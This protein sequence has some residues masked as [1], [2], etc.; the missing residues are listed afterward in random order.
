MGC[1][2]DSPPAEDTVASTWSLALSF[3]GQGVG[4]LFLI[5]KAE[6]DSQLKRG[7]HVLRAIT[8]PWQRGQPGAFENVIINSDPVSSHLIA[9]SG[10][11]LRLRSSLILLR[12]VRGAVNGPG[13][14]LGSRESR[15]L[16]VGT[17]GSYSRFACPPLAHPSKGAETISLT[18]GQA[19]GV[20][21][22]ATF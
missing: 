3:T 15:D 19:P 9:A 12:G 5:N 17:R 6:T 13:P 2:A 21:V 16:K 20:D 14:G 7:C 18:L 4:F 22:K 1:A 8:S 10:L 11:G